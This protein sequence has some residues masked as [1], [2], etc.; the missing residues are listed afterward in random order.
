MAAST[1]LLATQERVKHDGC[2]EGDDNGRR[3]HRDL[4]VGLLGARDW[5]VAPSR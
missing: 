2:E 1:P 5:K 4:A 3:D